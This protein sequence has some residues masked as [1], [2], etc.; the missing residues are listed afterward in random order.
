MGWEQITHKDYRDL[1]N[2]K[3]LT[4]FESA[5]FAN[6]NADKAE[7]V[8]YLIYRDSTKAR[9]GT[10]G[11]VKNNSIFFPF[12][13]P[14]S[15]LTKFA[16][17]IKVEHYHNAIT[18]L[19]VFCRDK[20]FYSIQFTLPPEHY[21]LGHLTKLSHSF[22]KNVFSLKTFDLNHHFDLRGF[23]TGSYVESLTTKCRQKLKASFKAGLIF[24]LT[25]DL[26]E[27]YRIIKVNRESKG[28]PL[29]MSLEQLQTTLVRLGG[30][31]FLVKSGKLNVASAVTFKIST[32][33]MQVIYWGNIPETEDVRPMNFLSYKMFEFY[34]LRGFAS[35]DIGPSTDQGIANYGLCDF[36]ESIGCKTTAKLTYF[37]NFND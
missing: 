22:S 29:R 17:E 14:Y 34:S 31:L 11:G 23:D 6:L 5:D 10:I 33:V 27:V 30:D 25:D 32:E 36:K 16:D 20:N 3:Y 7:E 24:E 35:L 37:K 1:F 26:A 9:F 19:E 2:K 18:E 21:S 13:A 28:Y 12:S 8:L 4:T 15:N